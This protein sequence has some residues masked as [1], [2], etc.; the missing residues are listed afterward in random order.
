M[1][2]LRVR[3]VFTGITGSPWVNTLNFGGPAQTGN[4][5]DA[6][7]AVAATGVFWSAVDAHMNTAVQWTTLPDVLFLGDDGIAA[8]A[9]A[10]TPQTGSGGAADSILPLTSQALVRTLTSVFIG[11][12]QIRGR[13]FV[14]GLTE[15]ANLTG[16]LVAGV[17]SA[18]ATAAQTLNSVATPPLAVWS[19]ANG[20]VTPVS[21][22]SV[23][24]QF[25]VLRSR[26]D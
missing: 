20:T 19:K 15:A 21:A 16:Q 7:A 26:R 6:D 14:P 5:T 24:S 10:T 1:P 13:I 9:Y 25:A 18:I 3:T 11:G 22:V 4:Q 12:R 23:W 17:Q 8:A 2:M